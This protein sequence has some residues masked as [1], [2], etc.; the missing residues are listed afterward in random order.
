MLPPY[1]SSQPASDILPKYCVFCRRTLASP[2][3]PK[4]DASPTEE[5]VIPDWLLRAYELSTKKMYPARWAADTGA[6]ESRRSHWWASLTMR[7]VCYGC[8]NGWSSDLEQAAKPLI[9]PLA[10]QQTRLDSLD[11]ARQSLVARWAAKTALLCHWNSDFPRFIPGDAVAHLK[12]D[13]LPSGVSVFAYQARPLRLATPIN[14]VQSQFWRTYMPVDNCLEARSFVKETGKISVR[15]QDLHFLVTYVPASA[16][17]LVGWHRVHRPL[18]PTKPP[19]WF[20][21]CLNVDAVTPRAESAM[22]IFH[23]SL[24]LAL[25][26]SDRPPMSLPAPDIAKMHENFYHSVPGLD[27]AAP[28]QARS[29]P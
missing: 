21:A 12:S 29:R 26:C 23:L 14:F 19:L 1:V 3:D 4:A 9:I 8:N 28:S 11:E 20:D 27:G 16:W 10:A 24:G 7:D 18:S 6:L 13:G 22:M 5:H 17:N 2:S 15:I 25:N